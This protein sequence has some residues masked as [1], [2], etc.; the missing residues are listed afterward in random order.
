MVAKSCL[1]YAPRVLLHAANLRHGT[2]NFTSLPKEG[3]LRIFFWTRELGYQRP[4]RYLCIT[5]AACPTGQSAHTKKSYQSKNKIYLLPCRVHSQLYWLYLVLGSWIAVVGTMAAY[6][7]HGSGFE[8][9]GS[10]EIFSS[11]QPFRPC[12]PT[13]L[14]PHCALIA[15]HRQNFPCTFTPWCYLNH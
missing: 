13:P 1:G 3:V 15:C 2:N 8:T 6:R 12:T 7:L 14:L 9:E 10:Q 5:E 4:A 11:W